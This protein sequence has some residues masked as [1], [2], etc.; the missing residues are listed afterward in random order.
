MMTLRG[1]DDCLIGPVKMW[2]PVEGGIEQVIL[3]AYSGIA[4]CQKIMRDKQL[5]FDQARDFI[6]HEL[7]ESA[8]NY[9][10]PATPIL[11]WPKEELIIESVTIQ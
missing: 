3:L 4:V 11:V 7:I 1:F 8:E 10:G 9:A 2:T 5:S 6:E